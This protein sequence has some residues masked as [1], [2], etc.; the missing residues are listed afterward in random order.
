MVGARFKSANSGQEYATGIQIVPPNAGTTSCTLDATRVA[1]AFRASGQPIFTDGNP[2]A[3][4]VTLRGRS[5]LITIQP[6]TGL[7]AVTAQ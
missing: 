1:I 2:H 5:Y 7:A 4:M 6:F 3:V